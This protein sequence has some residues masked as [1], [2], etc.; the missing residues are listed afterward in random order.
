MD[1]ITTITFDIPTLLLVYIVSVLIVE[2]IV[3]ILSIYTHIIDV[4]DIL[5]DL[6]VCNILFTYFMIFIWP[7]VL[8]YISIVYIGS[9]TCRDISLKIHY[10][11]CC[12]NS[13]GERT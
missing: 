4:D 12:L 11:I 13:R 9:Y 6:T 3:M 7:L 1:S 2:R 5:R 8:V 10:G